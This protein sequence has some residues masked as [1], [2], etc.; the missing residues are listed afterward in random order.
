MALTTVATNNRVKVWEKKFFAEYVRASPFK[1]YMGTDENSIIQIKEQ[2]MK[3]A[4]DRIGL[5]LLRKLR[6][7]GVTGSTTLVGN[8]ESVANYDDQI[9]V[10]A[11]R[12]GVKTNV[13]EEQR[14]EIGILDAGRTLLKLW[15]MEKM[16][17]T[18]I[19]RLMSPV[20]DGETTYASA[21]EAQKDTWLTANSDRV[22]VGRSIS[23]TSSNDH[24]TSLANIDNTN[25]KLAPTVI[26]LAKRMARTATNGIIRPI[27]VDE[28]GEWYV[29]WCHSLAFR[30]LSQHATM[31]NAHQYAAERG[32]D[33]PLFVD[34][35][36]IWRGVICIEVP[37]IP[38]VG[39]V[40]A[41]NIQVVPNFLCGAQALGI[42][43]AQ[44]T[45]GSTEVRD[46][47]FE[48]GAAISEI[49]GMKKL[50]FNNVQNG[51]LTLYTAGV[52]DAA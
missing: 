38:V 23:N 29:L 28:D 4:G 42:G 11:L 20:V 8:E 1:R 30:D 36:L 41:G 44:R 24:S 49:R 47:G 12:H 52:E 39:A 16:R 22:L 2:L 37:E 43:W 27:V 48:Q 50:M 13:L 5:T 9:T 18:L 45:K 32:K 6:G 40:G 15:S 19:A 7:A 14:T 17:D 26:E 31:I 10:D 21:S 46:Y 3:Q 51:V 33:N 34:G 25:D 35:A